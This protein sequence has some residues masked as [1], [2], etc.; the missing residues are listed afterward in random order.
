M[1]RMQKAALNLGALFLLGASGAA[2]AQ[3]DLKIGF[4]NLN[5]IIQNAPQ[6]PE[7]NQQLRSEFAS[8]DSEFQELQNQY[9]EKLEMYERDRDVM[10]AS[11]RSTLERDLTQMQ[12]DIERRANELQEDLQIRQNELLS[13]LQVEILQKVQTY[14]Q[15]NGFDLVVSDA[16]YAS[17]TIN[18]TAAVYEAITGQ[19]APPP[20]AAGA[21]P[22]TSE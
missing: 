6:I 1:T 12:R 7:I 14:A 15:E 10:S 20:G 13:A 5:A 17:M 9:N 18:I 22:T 16:V 21:A 8:R 2:Q 3:A 11:E 19:T 4:V